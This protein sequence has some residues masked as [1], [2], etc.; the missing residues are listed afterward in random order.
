MKPLALTIHRKWFDRIASGQKT[1]EF[2]EVKP[3]WTKR[4]EGRHYDEV[5][6]RNGYHQDA[7]F[8]R[9]EYLG[10]TKNGCYVL[11]LGKVLETLN[12]LD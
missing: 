10:Y 4:L 5:H 9:V 7:P 1:Q 3:Y 6:F 12:T 11:H 8:M 2:R